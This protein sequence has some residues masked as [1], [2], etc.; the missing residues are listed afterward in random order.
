MADNDDFD[1]DIYGDDDNTTQQNTAPVQSQDASLNTTMADAAPSAPNGD[2]AAQYSNMN[3]DEAS[4]DA[5]AAANGGLVKQEYADETSYDQQA[6]NSNGFANDGSN[7][8]LDPDSQ[9]AVIISDLQWWVNDDDIRGWARFVNTEDQ[10][11]EIT[12]SEHKVNGKCKG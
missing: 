5:E 2:A 3:V 1:I 9:A 4:G 7:E 12:F 6:S 10:L 8:A 11:L